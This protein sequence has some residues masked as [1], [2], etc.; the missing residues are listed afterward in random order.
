L[1]RAKDFTRANPDVTM[2][3]IPPIMMADVTK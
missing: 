1:E 2:L 3:H